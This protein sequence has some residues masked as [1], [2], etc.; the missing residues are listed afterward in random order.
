MGLFNRIK[1]IRNKESSNANTRPAILAS[2]YNKVNRRFIS[3]TDAS[4]YMAK[5]MHKFYIT[6][7]KFSKGVQIKNLLRKLDITIPKSGFIYFLDEFKNLDYDGEIINSVVDYSV[8]LDNSI[9]DM[10]EIFFNPKEG[11]GFKNMSSDYNKEMLAVLDGIELLIYEIHKK[12]AKSSRED[13]SKYIRFFEDMIDRKAEHFEEALQRI[14]FFNQLL[15]QTGH[16]LNSLGRLDKVLEDL[17]FDDLNSGFITNQDA[18]EL[19]KDFMKALH[20]YSWYKVDDASSLSSQVITLGGKYSD[21]FGQYYFYNDLTYMFLRASGELDFNDIK[22]ALR[23]SYE[24]PDD[25]IKLALD[26]INTNTVYI[27]DGVALESNIDSNIIFS[28][29]E[30]VIDKLIDFGY[31]KEDAY[32]YVISST[33]EP[34]FLSSLEANNLASFSLLEPLN[35]IFEMESK[36]QIDS[37][38][39]FDSFM[40]IY[41]Y[42]LKNEINAVIEKVDATQWNSD[43]L[44]SLLTKESYHHQM[45]ISQGSSRNNNYGIRVYGL[46]NAVNSLYNLKKFV[47]EDKIIGL[48]DLN[49]MRS[50]NFKKKKYHDIYAL[51][52]NNPNRFGSSNQEIIDLS[53]DIISYL[54]DH[55]K[56]YENSFDGRL[57]FGLSAPKHMVENDKQASF[58]GSLKNTLPERELLS[59]NDT[60]LDSF[61]FASKLD[62]GQSGFNGNMIELNLKDPKDIPEFFVKAIGIGFNQ[63]Q[64]NLIKEEII[65]KENEE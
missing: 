13:K 57:K 2:T 25:L 43:P 38:A 21:E 59:L 9:Y 35:K 7:S 56:E 46:E 48:R 5:N 11:P 15:Y 24:T 36:E 10:N 64:I 58:D 28:H 44:L 26:S 12:L 19:V 6:S 50:N 42:N 45:D 63:L 14:L 31:S 30:T 55:V 49:K 60:N 16:S 61:D 62:Y 22:V 65:V 54:E 20:S 17:Y 8:I 23:I 34:T 32:G 27:E 51:L 47:F 29:D 33:L 37:I 41:K 39:D 3:S 52:K 40:D 53:N 18:Y 4:S 1:E